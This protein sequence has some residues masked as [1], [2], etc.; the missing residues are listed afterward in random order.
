[1]KELLTFDIETIPQSSMSV[2]QQE[3]FDKRIIQFLRRKFGD[4]ESY[5]DS[6]RLEVRGITMATTP[7]LGEIVCIG[8]HKV[9]NSEEGSIALIGSEIEILKSFWRNLD[10]WKGTFI[11]FNGL[12]FDVPFIIKRSMHLG[13]LPTNNDFLDLKRFSRWPHFDVKAVIGDFDK[14]ATGNLDLICDFVGVD[15]PKHGDIKAD[16]VEDA[17]Y[18]G[19]INLIAEYCL[20]DVVATYQ[21]YEKIKNYTY[22]NPKAY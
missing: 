10:G 17:F 1:M 6:E 21:V 7:Y 11:S 5:T 12:D 14:F 16:G 3:E 19:K 13:I 4:K 20:R 9:T 2:A 22:K 15:S 8:L 18:A